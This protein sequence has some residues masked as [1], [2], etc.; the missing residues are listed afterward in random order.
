MQ[1]GVWTSRGTDD[2]REALKRLHEI[3]AQ[4]TV[5]KVLEKLGIKAQ[6]DRLEGAIGCGGKPREGD[7]AF[8]AKTAKADRRDFAEEVNK[9]VERIPCRSTDTHRMYVTAKNNL[10]RVV[11]AVRAARIKRWRE[12]HGLGDRRT[13]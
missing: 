8:A 1:G 12:Q 13:G 11:A 2:R 3:E 7:D 6:L 9:F 5:T 4:L 10:L